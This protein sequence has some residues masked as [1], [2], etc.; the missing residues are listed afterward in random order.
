MFEV[1]RIR[2]VRVTI[3]YFKSFSDFLQSISSQS[4]FVLFCKN[5]EG[6]LKSYSNKITIF[7][8]FDTNKLEF[9]KYNDERKTISLYL[10]D[11]NLDIVGYSRIKL[12]IYGVDFYPNKIKGK[13]EDFIEFEK[14]F[15]RC[16]METELI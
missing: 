10:N 6:Y 5:K 16:L 1:N 2:D 15:K 9:I 13:E 11:F 12:E 4:D 8:Y 3:R 14:E 7:Y